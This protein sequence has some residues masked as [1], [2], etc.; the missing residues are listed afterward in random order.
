MASEPIIKS[1]VYSNGKCYFVSTINRQ[2]SSPLAPEYIY[3]ETMAWEYYP[4]RNER[5]KLVFQG[6]DGKGQIDEHI[7]ICKSISRGDFHE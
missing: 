1:Y 2:S 3:A 5:G 7:R 6:G 4:D